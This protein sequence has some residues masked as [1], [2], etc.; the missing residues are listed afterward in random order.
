MANKVFSLRDSSMRIYDG[1]ASTPQYVSMLFREGGADLPMGHEPGE[2]RLIM[3]QGKADANS[4][5]IKINDEPTYQPLKGSFSGLLYDSK[6]N[7]LILPALSNPFAGTWTVGAATFAP[8]TSGG[9]IV[10]MDGTSVAA[11]LPVGG[12]RN[13]LV[14]VEILWDSDGT[15]WGLKYTACHFPADKI[16]ISDDFPTKFKAEFDCYG[17]VSKLATNHTTPATEITS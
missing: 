2:E 3:H 13:N 9:N 10:N 16:V 17:T 12:E 7:N 5:R 15:D 4:H 14:N 1:T 6:T 11:V 8:V